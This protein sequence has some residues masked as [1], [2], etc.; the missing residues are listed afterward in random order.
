MNQTKQTSFSVGKAMSDL[1]DFQ[2]KTVA[3]VFHQLFENDRNKMLVADEVGLGKTIVA[4]GLIAKA[5]ERHI[6]TKPDQEFHVIYICSNQALASQNLKKLNL[7]G[8]EIKSIGRLVYLAYEP[9]KIDDHFRLSSLTPGTSFYLTGGTGEAEERLVLFTL[10]TQYEI[11]ERNQEGLRFLLI[12]GVNDPAKWRQRTI[13]FKDNNQKKFR[14]N[15][16]KKFKKALLKK[17]IDKREQKRIFEDIGVNRDE[18]SLWTIVKSYSKVLHQNNYTN[19]RARNAVVGLMRQALTEVCLEY[20]NAN[21]FILDEFQRY[22]DLIGQDE[23]SPALKLA[24]KVFEIEGAKIL[25]LSATP[26][27]PYTSSFDLNYGENHYAEFKMVL[28]F[29]MNDKDEAFWDDY[30]TDRKA[31]FYYLRRPKEAVRQL[32]EACKTKKRLEEIYLN[33]MTRTE[34]II[35]SDDHNMLLL[36]RLDKPFQLDSSDIKDFIQIDKI[37]RG[38]NK[39]F[40]H[41]KAYNPIEYSKSAPFPLSFMDRYKLKDTLKKHKDRQKIQKLLKSHQDGWIDFKK[42]NSYKPLRKNGLP[43]GKLRFLLKDT[44]YSGGYK[45][46]WVP[47]AIPYYALDGAYEGMEDFSKTLVFSSWV[48]VPRMIATLVS[49]EAERLTIGDKKSVSRQEKSKKNIRSYFQKGNNKRTP[50]PQLVFSR[51][52]VGRAV[53][54]MSNFC[55]LYPSLTLAKIYHPRQNLIEYQ[56]INSIR[57]KIRSE[58]K[59]LI[60]KF[61]LQR[62]EDEEGEPSRWYWAAPLLLDKFNKDAR[63]TIEEWIHSQSLPGYSNI[64]PEAKEDS[65]EEKTSENEHFHAF[66]K[67]FAEPEAIGLGKMP[68]DLEDVI[69]DMVLGSPAVS[70]LRALREYFSSS[71]D[72]SKGATIIAKGFVTLFNKPESIA[73]LRLFTKYNRYWRKVLDYCAC[74]N[75]QAMID[76]FI[77]LLYECE[78]YRQSA[79]DLA[80]HFCAVMNIRTS[81]IRVDSLKS[82]LAKNENPSMRCHFALDFGNQKIETASGKERIINLREAFNSPF[83]PFILASTSIGQEGLDFHYYCRKVMHWNLP[84]N[85]IDIEQREGRINRYMGHVIR[86]NIALK[87]LKKLKDPMDK[88]WQNLFTLAKEKEQANQ[89]CDLVPYWHI[90]C[91][92]GAKIERIIPLHPYSK[93]IGKLRYL[94][95]VLAFYRLTFGQPRQE[96]LVEAI[97]QEDMNEEEIERL[98]DSLMINLSPIAEGF[99]FK[100]RI[101][102]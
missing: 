21:L 58:I 13:D 47:P 41:A 51:T 90:D 61:D 42:V 99:P 35:V 83:K 11:F 84:G 24:K 70:A 62:F 10:L 79:Q 16:F 101:P 53:S 48:L 3:Y 40:P 49:Y 44:L 86:K 15:V 57:D 7:L 28:K 102:S 75:I 37:T 76:E 81:S 12:G 87:Y 93:D 6:A 94:L 18:V 30:E 39:I 54:N 33:A 19:Y 8:N 74:G 65:H 59:A 73:T 4:R 32:P 50:R 29:L 66:Y 77:Y 71:A 98:F 63:A 89:K 23:T 67:A 46:L 45:L 56:S 64:D 34:R 60:R 72:I 80:D 20:L 26:F 95:E 100:N 78:N 36:N 1:K 88:I 69:T 14:R 55:I 92:N 22:R 52:G 2:R 43:N 38:L 27:K 91:E 97:M 68:D 85:A 96:E 5:Y 25:M 31:L 17:R 9:Y 82:F